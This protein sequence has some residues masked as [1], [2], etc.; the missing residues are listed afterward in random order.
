MRI[1]LRGLALCAGLLMPGAAVAEGQSIIVLDAS[2]SMWGQIEGRAKLEIAREALAAVVADMPAETAMGLMAYGHR[3]KG[4]CSDIELIV[5]PGTGT[6]PA[7]IE[8]ANAMNFLGKTPLSDAVRQAAA[9]LRSTEE[10]ATVILITD[11]IETCNADPCAL[12]TELEASGVDFT[13]HVVGFGLTKEE[14]AQVACLATNTGGQYIEAKDAG[15]LQAALK[16]AVVAPPAPEPEP[17]PQP[18]VLAENVD[19]VLQLVAGGPEPD[20]VLLQDAYFSFRAVAADGTVAEDATTIYGRSLGALPPGTYQ[21]VTTLHEA[22]VTQEVVIGPATEVSKPV[23]VL[24]AGVLSLRL[25][26]EEGGDPHPEAMWEMRGPDDVYSSGFAQTLRVFPAAEYALNARLGEM[27]ATDAVVITAGEITEK[28][29]VLSVGVPVFSAFYAPGVPV[30]GDQAFEVLAASTNLDGNRESITT[31]YGAGSDPELPPGDYILRTTVGRAQTE[32]PLTIKAGERQEVQVVLNAGIVAFNAPN[33]SA[34]DIFQAKMALDGTRPRV[35]T[36]FGETPDITL[37]AGDYLAVATAGE[38]T[39]EAPFTVRAGERTEVTLKAEVGAVAISAPGAGSIEILPAKA[40]LDGDRPVLH[41][42]YGETSEALLPPGDY[43]ARIAKDRVMTE[44][45]FTVKADERTE[46][47]VAL[48]MGRAQVVAVASDIIEVLPG[49]AA[50]DGSVESLAFDYGDE[51]ALMLPPGE[52]LAI[53]RYGETL[54][55]SP[56]TV[57]NG[58]VSEVT[59]AKP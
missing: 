42:D 26:A 49:G 46:L 3:E 34:I 57:T 20:A 41:V 50:T 22:E 4:S 11:G 55:Q 13:A 28:T 23:A 6:G 19:P 5:P 33:A 43:L 38:A 36:L 21:M 2:G 32:Q 48:E 7:I 18:A 10:K 9:A 31:V 52:Y 58:A 29:I 39:V 54:V 53:A 27:E 16:T 30:E 37:V 35:D 8:A 12:G 25:L 44:Q 59:L 24:D 40:T 1:S 47:K 17:E 15:S 56:M 14:G 45:P 51:L